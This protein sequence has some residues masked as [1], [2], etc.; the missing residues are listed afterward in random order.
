M[1]K[2]LLYFFLA[3]LIM[4]VGISCSSDDDNND[5]IEQ[6]NLIGEWQLTEVDFINAI[7]GGF[8]LDDQCMST[9]IL[10]YQ[11]KTSHDLAIVIGAGFPSG[12]DLW[13]WEGDENQFEITQN[14]HQYPPYNF[15]LSSENLHFEKV[16]GKWKMT[17]T[18]EL[19]HGSKAKFTMIKQSINQDLKPV[20]KNP[21]GSVYTC[22][23]GNDN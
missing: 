22:D 5:Y 19:A 8:P 3:A 17:F 14:N 7:P 20:I 18:S 1:K 16:D 10:G 23:Y 21:D 6:A 4:S 12:Q 11:F 2:G 15:G 13:T 9:L